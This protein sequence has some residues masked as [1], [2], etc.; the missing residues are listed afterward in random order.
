MSRKQFHQFLLQVFLSTMGIVIV[1]LS[2]GASFGLCAYF[3]IGMTE[4]HPVIPFLLLG[5][6]VDDMFVILEVT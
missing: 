2:V 4:L 1:Q 5:I 3:G 6:G